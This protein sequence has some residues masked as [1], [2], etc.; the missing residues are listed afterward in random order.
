M[1]A[2]TGGRRRSGR[3]R[4]RSR[5]RRPCRPGRAARA[6]PTASLAANWASP[7]MTPSLVV[8]IG[9]VRRRQVHRHVEVV[10]AGLERGVEDRR[11][12]PW[13]A[14]VDDHVGVDVPRRARRRRVAI[15]ASTRVPLTRSASLQW[16]RLGPAAA[17]VDVGHDD[18][19]EHVAP[20]ADRDASAEPTPPAPTISTRMTPR[21]VVARRARQTSRRSPAARGRRRGARRRR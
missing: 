10:A 15:D 16:P 2:R 8:R 5:A 19:L 13:V 20:S 4:R 9:R 21:V 1:R 7:S 17:G 3:R 6:R 12:E 14:G 11:V 18:V